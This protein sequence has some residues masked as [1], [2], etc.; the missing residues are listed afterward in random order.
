VD[1]GIYRSGM[2]MSGQIILGGNGDPPSQVTTHCNTLQ[3][4]AAHCSTLQHTLDDTLQHTATHCSTLQHT[5]AHCS[6]LQHTAAHCSTLQYTL[7]GNGDRPLHAQIVK[8]RP[9]AKV[10]M[11]NNDYRARFRETPKHI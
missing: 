4:T 9:A 6:T 11:Y 10:E 5:A 8:S 1:T 3:H 2:A 7:D